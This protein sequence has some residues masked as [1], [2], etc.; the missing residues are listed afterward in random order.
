VPGLVACGTHGVTAA[1]VAP[2]AHSAQ[3]MAD[4]NSY[5]FKRWRIGC[6]S[7]AKLAWRVK[8]HL[9]LPVEQPLPDGSYPSTV[10]DGGDH[11]RSAGQIVRGVEYALQGSATPA[12]D[13]CRLVTNIVDPAG[14]PALALVL[15]ELRGPLLAHFATGQPMARAAWPRGLDPGRPCVT[16]AARVIRRK[17]PQA[18]AVPPEHLAQWRDALQARRAH[19]GAWIESNPSYRSELPMHGKSTSAG[20][21]GTQWIRRWRCCGSRSARGRPASS[22][23]SGSR[24]PTSTT[25]PSRPRWTGP[26]SRAASGTTCGKPSP[27][28]AAPPGHPPRSPPG[29][30]EGSYR[31]AQHE[32]SP[33]ARSQPRMPE[34]EA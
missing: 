18:A 27:P 7:G 16:H 2:D 32:G 29:G 17:M 14:A 22:A 26:A 24:S 12:Q 21:S 8:S 13:S 11:R 1:E 6:A 10:F 5:G 25:W 19:Q 28:G 3:A 9:K 34:G 4:R 30:P 15:Q 23:T 20:W 31:R 33:A